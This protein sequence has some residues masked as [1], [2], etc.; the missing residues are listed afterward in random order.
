MK[1]LDHL[2]PIHNM[3]VLD[4]DRDADDGGR[5]KSRLRLHQ[6]PWSIYMTDY[7]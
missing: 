5:V 4:I 3:E 7:W 2:L 1:V 6:T